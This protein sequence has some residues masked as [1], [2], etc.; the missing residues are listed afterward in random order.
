MPYD[1]TDGCMMTASST[2]VKFYILFSS[3]ASFSDVVVPLIGKAGTRYKYSG[4]VKWMGSPAMVE[5]RVFALAVRCPRR[6]WSNTIKSA[7]V[8]GIS[9]EVIHDLHRGVGVPRA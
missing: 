8:D 5:A 9:R 2:S 6:L 1:T 7:G 4:R 3:W